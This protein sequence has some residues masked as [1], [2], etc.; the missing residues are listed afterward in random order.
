MLADAPYE[1]AD[2]EADVIE[3]FVAAEVLAVTRVNKKHASD[4]ELVILS[5]IGH[6]FNEIK[7]RGL[8]LNFDFTLLISLFLGENITFSQLTK[9]E[10]STRAQHFL[11][12]ET[13]KLDNQRENFLRVYEQSTMMAIS[14]DHIG[15]FQF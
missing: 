1:C 2:N 15:R 11:K 8:D 13:D 7:L 6:I 12:I 5:D 9:D 4:T 3:A 10:I 14:T